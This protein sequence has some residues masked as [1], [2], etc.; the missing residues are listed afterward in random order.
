M[1]GKQLFEQK[2]PAIMRQLMEDFDLDAI[3]AAGILGNIGHECNGFH[4]LHEIGQPAR[5]GGYG[6]CQWTG[7]RRNE[8]LDWCKQHHLDWKTDAANYGYLTEELRGSERAAISALLKTTTLAGAVKAFERNF[9]RAGVPNYAARN[10]W[11]K[12][13]LAAYADLEDQ[14]D[15]LSSSE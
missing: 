14:A 15:A 3:Q 5:R 8:F 6:W 12:L 7:P 9:E 2:S 13:A 11:A 1:R 4:N 10:Q